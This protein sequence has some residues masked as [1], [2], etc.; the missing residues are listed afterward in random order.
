MKIT[1]EIICISC[2]VGCNLTV[3]DEDGELKITGHQ[4]NAGILYAKEEMTNPTRN[5]ATSIRVAGGD[6][7]M[8]SIKTAG[9]I[10]KEAIRDVVAAIHKV[11]VAAPVKIGDVVLADA[12]GI[13]VDIVATRCVE[14]VVGK[15][16]MP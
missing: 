5:I 13:G 6:M 8:L 15:V 1:R 9:P 2:P 11:I 4:C 3:Q 16:Q 7:P 14:S 12:G 10:P